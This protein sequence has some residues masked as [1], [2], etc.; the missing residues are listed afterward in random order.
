ML[1]SYFS[2]SKIKQ[3]VILGGANYF[4]EVCNINK[5]LKLKTF[6]ITCSDQNKEFKFKQNVKIFDKINNNFKG[7]IKKISKTDNT[8]FISLGARWIFKK[9]S[10]HEIFNNNLVN[11]HCTRLPY[12]AGGGG[13]SWKIM[14]QDRIDSQLVHIVDEGVDTG[15]LLDSEIS[16]IPHQFQLPIEI[17]NFRVRNFLKFYKK[18]L[19][20]LLKGK[21]F[22]RKKQ[23]N[24]IGRYNPRLN[25]EINGWINWNY[26]SISLVNFIKAFDDP[27]IGSTTMINNQ[28][29]R[30]KKAQLH[31][32]DSPNHPFMTGLI[33]RHDKKWLV[34]STRDQ[35]NI[36]VEEV[37]NK[38]N[39]NII[40]NLKAGD[41]FF[42]PNEYL[43]RSLNTRIRYNTH[44]LKNK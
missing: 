39:Q 21:K 10:I 20:N 8:I 36:I 13:H 15:D 12:D 16:V 5:K 40:E 34:V 43:D 31:G 29:V 27:Y 28:L 6:I 42:T 3:V 44:G 32:G 7:Y 14:R 30:L 18:F 35:N 23:S 26:D 4:D 19:E 24:F 38:K 17:E 1:D 9:N 11:F 22:L 33:S 37:L 25:S 41:R 2:I